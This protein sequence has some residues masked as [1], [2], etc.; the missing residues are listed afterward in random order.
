M[1]DALPVQLVN[2]IFFVHERGSRL[3]LYTLAI[4]IGAAS[5]MLAGY[6]LN[7][8]MGYKLFFYVCTALAGLLLI[9]TFFIVEETTFHR[10]PSMPVAVHEAKSSTVE[11][12]QNVQAISINPRRPFIQQLVLFQGIDHNVSWWIMMIRPIT[13]LAVP[14]VLWI[15]CVYGVFIGLGGLTFNYTFPIVIVSPPYNWSAINSGLVAIPLIVGFLL[16]FIFTP[17]SDRL[18]AWSTR[19]NNGIRESEMRLPI[20]FIPC[21]LGPI[22]MIIYGLA[23][24]YQLSWVALVFPVAIVNF[25]SYFYFTNA[26]AYMVD[27]YSSNIAEMLMIFNVGRGVVSFALGFGL[28]KWIEQDGYAKVISGALS[29]TLFLVCAVAFLFYFIGKRVRIFT[30]K[31]FL[32]RMHAQSTAQPV[33]H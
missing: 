29:V 15:I 28:L 16:A 27:S 7:A 23:L 30:S 6:M 25:A 20:L 18:S 17:I 10:R 11:D 19:R 26:L 22:G 1:C 33:M 31:G 3:G 5:P 13:Y 8:N 2:D 14:V 4:S 32:A 21:F 24:E 9:A 12:E